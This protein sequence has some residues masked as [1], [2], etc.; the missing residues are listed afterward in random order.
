MLRVTACLA[1]TCGQATERETSM[2][3]KKNPPNWSVAQ[4]EWPQA[5][6]HRSMISLSMHQD[7]P[8]GNSR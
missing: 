7:S 1:G 3:A 8:M 5:T 6:F 2:I 4:L